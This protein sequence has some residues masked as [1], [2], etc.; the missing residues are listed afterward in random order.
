MQLKHETPKRRMK[1]KRRHDRAVAVGSNDVWAMD[2]VH[3]QLNT[4]KKLRVLAVADTFSRYVSCWMCV[5][6]IVEKMLSRPSTGHA[7][8][9]AIRRRS[10]SI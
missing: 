5:T 8:R 4:G 6:A 3:G 9:R 7:A 1:V 2:F 10:A